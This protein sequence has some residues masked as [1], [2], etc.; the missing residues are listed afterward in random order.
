MARTIFSAFF[1]FAL[2]VVTSSASPLQNSL[3]FGLMMQE[4]LFSMSNQLL[5]FSALTEPA[6]EDDY[7][8]RENATDANMR[9]KLVPGLSAEFVTRNAGVFA[10]MIAFW[11]NDTVYTHLIMCIE[12]RRSKLGDNPGVQRI[13]VETGEVETIVFGMSRCDGIRTTA[14]GTILATEETEDGAAYEIFDPLGT[15]DQ[16]VA[17]RTTGVVVTAINGTE[18]SSNIFKRNALPIM[19]WEGL[20]IMRSG[21]LYAGDELRPGSNDLLDSDGGAIFKFVPTTLFEEGEITPNTSPFV[22]G[23]TY[24]MQ[25]SCVEPSSSSF[26]QYGQGCEIGTSVWVEIDPTIARADADAKGATGYY[27]PEDLHA[28]PIYEGPGIRW[29]VANTGR[30]DADNPG[31]VICVVDE[32]P[33]GDEAWIDERTDLS[34]QSANGSSPLFASATR[35]IQ[36]GTRFNSHD[37]LAF[38]AGTGH[39]FVI[40][41][42]SFGEVYGCL[43]DGADDDFTSDGCVPFLSVI[44][45]EAEPS[46]FIFD[47]TGV[48][49]F[50]SIQHGECPDVL[51]DFVSNPDGGCTDDILKITG[52]KRP[53]SAVKVLSWTLFYH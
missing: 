17:N 16:W 18:V 3:D 10:D 12:G 47:G 22:S 45:P 39:L 53:K 25:V 49:A 2:V 21:V 29:C 11:P 4:K 5:G 40:E 8:P 1:V 34:Y 28:D 9:V 7:V 52:F 14:W 15:T 20:T 36:G 27:R 24:A 26:P 38:Q 33:L 43:N 31:E 50:V 44:D 35:F 13:D 32:T 23:S 42:D 41:D 48:V 46:G 6:T 30:A 51:K 37:N 19:A